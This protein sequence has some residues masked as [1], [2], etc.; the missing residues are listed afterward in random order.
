MIYFTALVGAFIMAVGAIFLA[1]ITV[2]AIKKPKENL[3]GAVII[4]AVVI[5]TA[6][7]YKQIIGG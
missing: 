6:I 2:N 5:L 1:S 4:W 7:I 3:Y